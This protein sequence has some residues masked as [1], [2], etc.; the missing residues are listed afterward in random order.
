MIKRI[1]YYS[2][3]RMKVFEWLDRELLG[4]CEFEPDEEGFEQF[5]DYLNY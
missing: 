1:F 2:G 3:Y 5:N 4:S